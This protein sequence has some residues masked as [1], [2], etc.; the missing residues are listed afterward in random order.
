MGA[1]VS[2]IGRFVIADEKTTLVAL[3]RQYQDYVIACKQLGYQYQSYLEYRAGRE[4][5]GEIIE[6]EPEVENEY[7]PVSP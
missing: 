3:K 1:G 7:G 4:R 5:T 2:L 6:K